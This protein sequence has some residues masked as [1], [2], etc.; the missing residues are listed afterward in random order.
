MA[1]RSIFR[2]KILRLLVG[3]GW[4]QSYDPTAPLTVNVVNYA[5]F[6]LLDRSPTTRKPSS[7]NIIKAISYLVFASAVFR[8][9]IA[10]LLAPTAIQALLMRQVGLVQLIR[11]GLTAAIFAIGSMHL[12]VS[13]LPLTCFSS[14]SSRC[15]RI[16]IFGSSLCCG[17]SLITFISTSSKAKVPN[18]V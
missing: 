6:L 12:P 18:G 7:D 9:E 2:H 13:T 3:L 14:Q 5:T 1:A 4:L 8:A 15:L 10:L 17:L 11:S 16:H